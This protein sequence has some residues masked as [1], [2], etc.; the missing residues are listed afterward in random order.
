MSMTVRELNKR[1]QDARREAVVEAHRDGARV[2]DIAY[3][4]DI[5]RTRV[6][7]ILQDARMRDE[8][9]QMW[10]ERYE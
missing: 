1:K 10:L 4:F 8:W 2:S 6:Q 9:Y 7:Q 3:V 5:S